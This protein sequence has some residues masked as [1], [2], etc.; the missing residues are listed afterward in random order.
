MVVGASSLRQT[1]IV[2]RGS[3]TTSILDIPLSTM[4]ITDATTIKMV[5]I[6]GGTII[7]ESKA[8]FEGPYI[9]LV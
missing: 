8:R 6:A 9:D 2:E 1:K 7:E 4:V 3:K 5:P